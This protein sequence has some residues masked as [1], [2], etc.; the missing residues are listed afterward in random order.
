MNMK[1]K[2]KYTEQTGEQEEHLLSEASATYRTEN[3]RPPCR[4]TLEELK[5][6]IRQ[7]MKDVK[8]GRVYQFEDV[9]KEWDTW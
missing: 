8:A 5:E 1:E 9:L 7:S 2:K 3:K 4:F 6:E